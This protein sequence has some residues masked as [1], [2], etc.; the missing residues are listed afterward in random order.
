MVGESRLLFSSGVV[1]GSG[2]VDKLKAFFF[3]QKEVN[4]N[5]YSN[6]SLSRVLSF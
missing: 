4:S 5:H 6:Y 2:L 1:D 3:S